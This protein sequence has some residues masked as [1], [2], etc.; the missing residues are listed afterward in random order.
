MDIA[1]S[2]VV[3]YS[4]AIRR[5]LV[6][7]HRVLSCSLQCLNST[8]ASVWQPGAPPRK[9]LLTSN[10]GKPQ[11]MI[12][13]LWPLHPHRT[14]RKSSWFLNLTCPNPGPPGAIMKSEPEGGRSLSLCRIFQES[15]IYRQT[16]KPSLPGARMRAILNCKCAKGNFVSQQKCFKTGLY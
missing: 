3:I 6:L 13:V 12:Q 8:W 9:Q 1:I 15:Q 7:W 14:P 10:L 5:R 2:R 4:R 11:K 16:V